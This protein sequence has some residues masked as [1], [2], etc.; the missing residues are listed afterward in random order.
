MSRGIDV[1][2]SKRELNKRCGQQLRHLNDQYMLLMD[3]IVMSSPL[4]W[5]NKALN[6]VRKS[7]FVVFT[8]IIKARFWDPW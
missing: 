6:T 8:E 4:D 5:H 2:L 1:F 7:R 3:K